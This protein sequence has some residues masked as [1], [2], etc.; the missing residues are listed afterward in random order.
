MPLI[1]MH[2]IRC[3][4][5]LSLGLALCLP[6]L[7]Q[8]ARQAPRRVLVLYSYNDELPW[9]QGVRQGL[10]AK[11]PTLPPVALY[12]ERLDT[13]RLG[14]AIHDAA[15]VEYLRQKYRSV[16]FQAVISESEYAALF[17][18]RHPELFAQAERYIVN[19]LTF[20]AN[21]PG[22]H[23][24]RLEEQLEEN[25]RTALKLRPQTRRLVVVGNLNPQRVERLRELWR[26]LFREQLS[27]ETWTDD[28]SFDELYERAAHLP[29]NAIIFYALVNH[30]RTGARDTPY[31]VLEKLAAQARGPVFATH[32]TLMGSGT[33][34]GY[35][36][37]A[38]RVGEALAELAAGASPDRYAD[39]HFSAYE[40]DARALERWGI[41]EDRLPP[42]SVIRYA[43]PGVWQA[44][45]GAILGVATFGLVQTA[46]LLWLAAA[47][48]GKRLALAGMAAV[49]ARL[50]QHV[51]ERTAE[52]SAANARLAQMSY[53]DGLTHLANR[54]RFDETLELEFQRLKR[55][56]TPFSL[57][58]LDID[59][60][61][62]FNDHYGHVA[63]DACLVK[64]AGLIASL[65]SRP[66]DLAARYGGE[67]FTVILSGTDADGAYAIAER[68]RQGVQDL[69]IPH[70]TSSANR[71]ITVSIGLCTVTPD[72]APDSTVDILHL[73]DA[74]LYLAK[75]QGRNRISRD[76]PA[77]RSTLPSGWTELAED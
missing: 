11:L 46:L 28:F 40:F 20:A 37:S 17:L 53:I 50:E 32:D 59:F 42:G 31:A 27:L 73:A 38:T 65:V 10:K 26:Q 8:G 44:H 1:R 36:M 63:G 66:T 76:T 16:D 56:G 74:Q 7:A 25:L 19:P 34:G 48:R 51:Q 18:R 35:L 6:A 30:D 67:E 47:L 71:Y 68:I 70:H 29:D 57:L 41:S 12:E 15:W 62:N 21:L 22:Y 3:V 61:K 2:R 14:T 9:Q 52:L 45:R 39:G 72:T 58:L 43:S 23:V 4:F 24:L 54:R 77:T 49:R 13:S 33:V 5:L 60:F 75:E 64:V 55:Y 69:A